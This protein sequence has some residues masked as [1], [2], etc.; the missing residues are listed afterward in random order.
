MQTT[1]VALLSSSILLF[2]S[3]A[4]AGDA[5][6]VILRLDTVR[7]QP[8]EL[9]SVSISMETTELVGGFDFKLSADGN[10][11][12]GIGWD[13]PLFS[14]G[15][16]GWDTLNADN[17]RTVSAACI[18]TQDQVDPGDHLLINAFVQVPED[19]EP[20]ASS[21]LRRATPGSRTTSSTSA[22]WSSS[23]VAFK[24]SGP[25]ISTE[26]ERSAPRISESFSGSGETTISPT[27]PET[28]RSMAKISPCSS[29]CGGLQAEDDPG[30]SAL[31][32]L[33]V[34]RR[35]N[36]M[37]DIKEAPSLQTRRWLLFL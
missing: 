8:G 21:P 36:H 25:R 10:D 6:Q 17:S 15:W 1:T 26:M 23:M 28:R 37:T 22:R 31:L 20:E 9:V 11:I 34:P 18:F 19:A 7:A 29:V 5:D 30:F 35:R 12:T 2:T 32:V 3:M 13:G 33:D 27:L 16:T 24:F 4:M 14:N